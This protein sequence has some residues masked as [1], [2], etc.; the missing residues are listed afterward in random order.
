MLGQLFIRR[1]WVFNTYG[2][3]YF[4]HKCWAKLTLPNKYY[5]DVDIISRLITRLFR[6]QPLLTKV[7]TNMAQRYN[8]CIKMS[9]LRKINVLQN[10]FKTSLTQEDNSVSY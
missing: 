7:F 6:D 9:F 2:D 5:I 3:N 4:R 1:K 10:L 8:I